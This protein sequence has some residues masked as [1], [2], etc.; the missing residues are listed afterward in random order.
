MDLLGKLLDSLGQQTQGNAG[1][2]QHRLFTALVPTSA[3]CGST[4]SVRTSSPPPTPSARSPT[5]GASPLGRF[6]SAYRDRFA[7]LPSDTA[8]RR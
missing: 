5:G 4:G 2:L 8:A 1:G 6:A 7:E 3:I